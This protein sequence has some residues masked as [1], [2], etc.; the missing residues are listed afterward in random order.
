ME[1][2]VKQG[3]EQGVTKGLSNSIIKI[4]STYGSVDEELS[5]SIRTESDKNKLDAWLDL[6]L[7]V[8]TVE[9]FKHFIHAS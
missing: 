5:H 4:L 7:K 3:I 9:E 1:L 6:A 8:E 2:G